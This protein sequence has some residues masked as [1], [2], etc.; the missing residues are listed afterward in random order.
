MM[1]HSGKIWLAAAWIGFAL[2]PWH[3][4]SAGWTEWVAGLSSDGPRSAAAL[5]LVGQAWWLAPIVSALSLATLPLFG[6]SREQHGVILSAAGLAGLAL[7]A[8]QGFAIGLDGWGFAPLGAMFGAPGPRQAG[9]GLGA[10]LT[11]ASCLMLLCHGLAARGWCR[12]DAFVVSAIGSVVALTIVFVFFPVAII[13]TSAI[14]DD[15]GALAFGVFTA[16]FFDRSIWGLDCL[17]SNLRCGVAW[18]TLF[19]A[20]LEIGRAHV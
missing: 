14:K 17:A 9:M 8:A 3:T 19:L 15:S 11:T 6:A 4:F 20:V 16:K 5:I 18:N 13:L 2:L 7:I 10:A 1:S 12:G